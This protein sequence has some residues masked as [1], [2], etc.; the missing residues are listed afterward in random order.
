[1]P[2]FKTSALLGRRAQHGQVLRYSSVLDPSLAVVD[3]LTNYNFFTCPSNPGDRRPLLERGINPIALVRLPDRS[4]R[5]P[6]ILIRSS[7]HKIG[8][9]S[10]PWQDIFDSDNGRVVYF[11]DNKH[12]GHAPEASPGNRALLATFKAHSSPDPHVRASAPPLL[13]F[14]GIPH[15]GRTKGQVVFHGFGIIR[16]VLLVTQYHARSGKAFSNYRFECSVFGLADEAQEFDW[17]WINARRDQH[18]SHEEALELAPASWK[19]WVRDGSGALAQCQ[20]RLA[21]LAVIGKAAQRPEQGSRE[22]R[23]LRTVYEYYSGQKHRFEALA[24]EVVGHILDPRGESYVPGWITSR[25]GDGGAD[26]VGRL[27]IGSGFSKVKVVVLGQAKCERLDAPTNGRDLA[28]TVARLRR[29][30]IGAYV[31]TAMFSR[32]AQEE[33]I[34][35]QYPILLVHGRRLASEVMVLSHQGGY[36]D[37]LSYLDAV[38]AKY[39][40]RVDVRRPEE[41]LLE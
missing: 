10:T 17:A 20:R 35:D 5:R 12:P 40:A 37:V 3:G 33:I 7:T 18:V 23:T 39:A 32:R 26:F 36:S 8:S 28:R 27:D 24:A 2:R 9:D 6:A 41:I 34:E 21:S 29:G 14:Q 4:T 31:T 13:F 30:W 38:D 19:R 22:H 15:D 25:S 16:R 1:M 11:G